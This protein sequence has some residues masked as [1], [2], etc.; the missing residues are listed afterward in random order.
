MPAVVAGNGG[1]NV[2]DPLYVYDGVPKKNTA[3]NKNDQT[4]I[5]QTTQNSGENF[6]NLS[7]Y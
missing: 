6:N 4:H 3:Q 5:V 1:R 2:L 7:F